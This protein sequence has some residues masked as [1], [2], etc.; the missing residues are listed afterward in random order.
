[1]IATEYTEKPIDIAVSIEGEVTKSSEDPC[2]LVD[3][4]KG[5]QREQSEFYAFIKAEKLDCVSVEVW[6]SAL[7]SIKKLLD[8]EKARRSEDKLSERCGEDSE[9]APIE[10]W[11]SIFPAGQDE[12][13]WSTPEKS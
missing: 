6:I 11:R 12:L 1:M 7:P 8:V 3:M 2:K 9:S 5:A 13:L 10:S 4:G